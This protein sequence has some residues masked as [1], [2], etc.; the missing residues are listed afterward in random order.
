MQSG[1]ARSSS[2]NVLMTFRNGDRRRSVVLGG[3]SYHEWMKWAAVWPSASAA[4]R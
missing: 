2:N 1:P 4:L 3:L